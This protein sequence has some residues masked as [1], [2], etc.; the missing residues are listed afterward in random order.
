MK[1]H[2]R[3]KQSLI[4]LIGCMFQDY[5]G[6]LKERNKCLRSRHLQYML[7]FSYW[8]Q[9]EKRSETNVYEIRSYTLKP[10]TMIEWGNN[11]ARGINHRRKYNEAFAGLFSHVGRLCEVYHIWCK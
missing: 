2:K 10:G 8:P 5:N 3:V 6:L 7:A 4:V 1:S 9:I 11:W